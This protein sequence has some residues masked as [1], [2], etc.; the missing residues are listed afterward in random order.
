MS[1]PIDVF[2]N[3]CWCFELNYPPYLESLKYQLAD[4][5]RKYN[6]D[7]IAWAVVQE[8]EFL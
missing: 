8:T 4:I 3:A 6:Q 5:A 2:Q 7:S 1:Q